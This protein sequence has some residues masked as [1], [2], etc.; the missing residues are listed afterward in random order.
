M[1]HP[2]TFVT[3]SIPGA[4]WLYAQF[5]R[6]LPLQRE[7]L[8]PLLIGFI[9]GTLILITIGLCLLILGGPFILSYLASEMF[10]PTYPLML[11]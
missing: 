9:T 4:V 8:A 10:L 11:K 1:N 3:S 7:L 2:F 6:L 5:N